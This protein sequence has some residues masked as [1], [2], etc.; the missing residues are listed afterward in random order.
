MEINSLNTKN[1]IDL[2]YP[3]GC[4]FETIDRNFDPNISWGGAWIKDDTGTVLVSKKNT[5]QFSGSV[6]EIVGNE[7]EILTVEQMPEH[8]HD[9]TASIS[10]TTPTASFTTRSV[11]SY[12]S[13]S[14]QYEM[15][16]TMG[17]DMGLH[18]CT[19]TMKIWD[20]SHA[21]VSGH[22]D[23]NLINP[24]VYTIDISMP[25][26]HDINIDTYSVGGNQ[27][28]STIQPSFIVYRWFRIE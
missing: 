25:H 26:K 10:E 19:S 21:V 15:V 3:V 14:S 16:G 23:G 17:Q 8:Y 13:S 5:G 6:G 27:G 1:I 20:G 11:A 9:I 28:Y 18:N 24:K 4:F 22:K 7:T 12:N 2:I